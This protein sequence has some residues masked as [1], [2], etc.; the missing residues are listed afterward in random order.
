MK[1]K[2][3]QTRQ[4]REDRELLP[5]SKLMAIKSSHHCASDPLAQVARAINHGL[6]AKTR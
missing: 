2:G 1:R 3:Q 5:Y 6:V 4:G